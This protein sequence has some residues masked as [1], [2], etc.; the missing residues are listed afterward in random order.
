MVALRVI[1]PVTEPTESLDPKDLNR[2]V[3]R[4]HHHTPNL[5]EITHKFKGSSVF[6]KLDARYGYWSVVL[7]EEYS[8]NCQQPIWQIQIY[9]SSLRTVYQSGYFLT[10]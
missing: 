4:S 8:Y 10:K 3:K 5:E 1:K 2:P 9:P 7:D 6:S